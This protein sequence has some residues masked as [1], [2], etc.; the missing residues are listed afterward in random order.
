MFRTLIYPSSGACDCIVELSH[1]SFCSCFAVCWRF[2]A[3]G[4]GWCSF[5][6]CASACNTDTTQNQPHQISNT[7]RN[8]NKTTD[9]VIQQHSRKLLK[10]DILMSETCWAHKKWNKIASDIKLVFHP[11]TVISWS[12]YCLA[13]LSPTKIVYLLQLFGQLFAECRH[14]SDGR[15]PVFKKNTT[16]FSI[17]YFWPHPSPPCAAGFTGAWSEW[18][19]STW[20]WWNAIDSVKSKFKST[21]MHHGVLRLIRYKSTYGT[22][23]ATNSPPSTE[24]SALHRTAPAPATR[25]PAPTPTPIARI[26][27]YLRVYHTNTTRKDSIHVYLML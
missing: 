27:T 9:V 23:H 6:S 19:M 25:T 21:R 2:G 26:D 11:S 18:Q 12:V 7:Q 3:A 20:Y 5:C 22:H 1:L 14:L 16:N 15:N 10:M 8:K 24:P 17:L 13:T 4:F